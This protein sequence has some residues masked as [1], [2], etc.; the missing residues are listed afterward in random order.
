MKKTFTFFKVSAVILLLAFVVTSSAQAQIVCP[1]GYTCTP[2]T[3][4][5]NCPDGY[6]CTPITTQSQTNCYNFTVSL[7]IGD[8]NKNVNDLVNA[9]V[10]QGFLNRSDVFQ[11]GKVVPVFDEKVAAAVTAFQEKYASEILTPNS[12]DHGTGYFGPFTRSKMNKLCPVVATPKPLVTPTPVVTPTPT[13]ISSTHAA[14]QSQSSAAQQPASVPNIPPTVT[15]KS[16]QTANVTI[17]APATIPLEAVANDSDGAIAKVEFFLDGTKIGEVTSAPYTFNAMNVGA[18]NHNFTAIA[19][20]NSGAR[21]TSSPLAAGISDNSDSDPILQVSP[22]GP[23]TAPASLN[24]SVINNYSDGVI[25]KIVYS[26][27][28]S[29]VGEATTRPYSVVLSGVAAGSYSIKADA[30]DPNG[31]LLG[32]SNIVSFTVASPSN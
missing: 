12:L 23:Y 3:H 7:K 17:W 2:I 25:G 26:N 21:T 14:I 19:T 28:N 31:T 1:A 29:K 6:V 13:V 22:S 9:L 11:G 5:Q 27:N 4:V 8:Q 20:D 30:Y 24:L 15:L 18:G 32:T 16:S 10:D